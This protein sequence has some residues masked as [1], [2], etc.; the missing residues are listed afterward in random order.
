MLLSNLAVALALTSLTAASTGWATVRSPVQAW[1]RLGCLAMV[2]S[3]HDFEAHRTGRALDDA[4]CGLDVVGVEILHLAFG[5]LAQ[6]GAGD[7][8]HRFTAGQLGA[9]GDADR[10]LDE[11][12][13]GR[14]LRDE[15]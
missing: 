2:L 5:D 15:G 12:A 9:G 7:L 14:R 11:V 1:M 13:G 8:A 4:R 6:L 10:L 3:L